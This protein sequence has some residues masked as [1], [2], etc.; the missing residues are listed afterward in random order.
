MT[1]DQK[2]TVLLSLVGTAPAV[3]SE[4]V[5][6]LAT[7]DEPVVPERV[8]AITTSTG[9]EK[10]KEKLF[11]DGHWKQMLEDL[12]GRGVPVG[13]KLRFGPIADSWCQ[14]LGRQGPFST[15]TKGWQKLLL[16]TS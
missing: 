12:E 7:Q 5:W 13:G 2:Q 11:K 10:I 3:L 16:A 15:G 9:A 8:I 14:P 1:T 4:T 6:A